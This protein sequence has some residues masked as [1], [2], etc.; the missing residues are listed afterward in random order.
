MGRSEKQPVRQPKELDYVFRSGKYQ[1]RS[2]KEVIDG[3]PNY[4]LWLARNTEIDF[5][6]K[7]IEKAEEQSEH[8]RP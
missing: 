3:D 5:D 2:V 6:H 1:G 8:W 7:V 4:I